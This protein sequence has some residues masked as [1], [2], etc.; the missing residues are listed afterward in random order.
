MAYQCFVRTH[1]SYRQ[2]FSHCALIAFGLSLS[3]FR[4]IASRCG[5]VAL[6]SPSLPNSTTAGLFSSLIC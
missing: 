3:F 6:F 2:F 5:L 4:P 1:Y